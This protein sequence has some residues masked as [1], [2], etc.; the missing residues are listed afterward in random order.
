MIFPNRTEAGRMLVQH[1]INYANRKDVI[2]LGSPRGGVP[3]A[4]EVAR[5][6][7]VLLDSLRCAN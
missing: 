5:M 3:V 4:F 2:V 6:L 1:L 7:K